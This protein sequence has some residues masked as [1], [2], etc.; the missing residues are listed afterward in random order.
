MP[1][2][3]VDADFKGAVTQEASAATAT[4]TS[5]WARPADAGGTDRGKVFIYLGEPGGIE[6]SPTPSRAPSTTR[7]SVSPS[8]AAGT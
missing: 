8:P 1:T 6:A 4:T 7:P 3:E 5:R 2:D